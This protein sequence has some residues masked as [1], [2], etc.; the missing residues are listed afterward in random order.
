MDTVGQHAEGD[1]LARVV[2]D[3]Y[4]DHNDEGIP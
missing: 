2:T 3:E 4:V 1:C